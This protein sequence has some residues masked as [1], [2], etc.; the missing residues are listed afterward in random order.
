M[1]KGNFPLLWLYMMVLTVDQDADLE[2]GQSE[3]NLVMYV[4]LSPLSTSSTA[5]LYKPA[6]YWLYGA[7]HPRKPLNAHTSTSPSFAAGTFCHELWNYGMHIAHRSHCLGRAGFM[8][9]HGTP[10]HFPTMDLDGPWTE[11]LIRTELIPTD[12][13]YLSIGQ[14][15]AMVH[16]Q[17]QGRE[18]YIIA[19][20]YGGHQK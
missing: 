16:S 17:G 3:N 8:T 6:I 11:K 20:A 4:T 1:L 5:P 18:M 12:S 15:V 2:C 7:S 13:L 10:A 19:A 14:R 9:C